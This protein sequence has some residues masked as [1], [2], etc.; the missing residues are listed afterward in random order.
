V[1]GADIAD[2]R[3]GCLDL[4]DAPNELDTA[5]IALVRHQQA[6]DTTT[7]AS[8]CSARSPARSQ[9]SSEG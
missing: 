7:P 2:D 4:L 6:I 8:A 5:A 9:S 3:K 1:A